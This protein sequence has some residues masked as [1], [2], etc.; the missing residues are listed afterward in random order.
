MVLWALSLLQNYR[1]YRYFLKIDT[2]SFF[3]NDD[4]MQYVK[5]ILITKLAVQKN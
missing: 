4:F 5:L 2:P 1:M 3:Y